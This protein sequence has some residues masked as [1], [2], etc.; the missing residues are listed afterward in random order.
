[1]FPL[2]DNFF[3]STIYFYRPKA[4][5]DFVSQRSGEKFSHYINT[6]VHINSDKKFIAVEK[7]NPIYNLITRFNEVSMEWTN[8]KIV[9][10]LNGQ[11]INEVDLKKLSAE[12]ESIE[13][14]FNNTFTLIMAI[15]L[16][17]ESYE[18]LNF[19]S[20]N[21]HKPYLYIDYIRV[22]K[23]NETKTNKD[24]YPFAYNTIIIV[25]IP[26]SL[27]ILVIIIAIVFRKLKVKPENYYTVI[28]S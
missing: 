14:I 18:D 17:Q 23:W 27:V 24:S 11:L 26:V 21:I 1:M 19:N 3:W 7:H 13:K 6:G 25:I 16:R 15:T 10:K 2:N 22:Y 20:N 5:I 12:N 9:W 28:F 8:E 4:N